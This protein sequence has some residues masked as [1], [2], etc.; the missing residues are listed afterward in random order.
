MALI[1]DLLYYPAGLFNKNSKF[2]ARLIR[3]VVNNM[4]QYKAN[5]MKM[6][7]INRHI[8]YTVDTV[9]AFPTGDGLSG[10]DCILNLSTMYYIIREMFHPR[11]KFHNERGKKNKK[12]RKESDMRSSKRKKKKKKKKDY[13]FLFCLCFLSSSHV[14]VC[15]RG[16]L[17]LVLQV[18]DNR[19]LNRRR[20]SK[21]LFSFPSG[22]K[23]EDWK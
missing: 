10:F 20:S 12:K 2:S 21:P 15:N 19:G 6:H 11:W 4:Q 9:L 1:T 5:V 7:R 3:L 14:C 18:T 13:C 23:S 17:D 16:N 8:A 22:Q